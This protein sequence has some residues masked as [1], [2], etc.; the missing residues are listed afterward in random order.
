VSDG[1]CVVTHLRLPK[2]VIGRSDVECMRDGVAH[3]KA[4]PTFISRVK[5]NGKDLS[6]YGLYLVKGAYSEATA[7]AIYN[8]LDRVDDSLYRS[9]PSKNPDPSTRT[10]QIVGPYFGESVMGVP[11]FANRVNLA[12]DMGT[13]AGANVYT[14][15]VKVP[16]YIASGAERL[17]PDKEFNNKIK[18]YNNCGNVM[19]M[20]NNSFLCARVL[21]KVCGG[22]LE[23]W[24]DKEEVFRIRVEKGDLLIM[25]AK[26]GLNPHKC[27]EGQYTIVTDIVLEHCATEDAQSEDLYSKFE[28][29]IIRFAKAASK[30]VATEESY[31]DKARFEL[32]EEI[33]KGKACAFDKLV[34]DHGVSIGSYTAK[35]PKPVKKPKPYKYVSYDKTNNTFIYFK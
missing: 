4:I 12:K 33:A 16:K 21:E 14:D 6:K 27:K 30:G 32:A 13:M 10:M 25:M 15:N 31:I 8:L 20:P 34:E 17:H 26:A 28:H 3:V 18:S 24:M 11:L 35:K 9:P 1:H 23:W 29:T 19:D 22:V 2:K 7:D 5:C